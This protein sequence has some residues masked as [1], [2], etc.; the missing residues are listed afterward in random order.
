MP[1]A[2]DH[3]IVW[4]VLSMLLGPTCGAISHE[5]PAWWAE[6]LGAQVDL[7]TIPTS[8]G[9]DPSNS[10]EAL[11]LVAALRA[12]GSFVRVPTRLGSGGELMDPTPTLPFAAD[13]ADVE[14]L[15]TS[16]C[17]D[18]GSEVDVNFR[19]NTSTYARLH[20]HATRW[21][22]AAHER[23]L[24]HSF[25]P[26]FFDHQFDDTGTSS[27]ITFAWLL[28][29]MGAGPSHPSPRLLGDVGAAPLMILEVGSFEGSSATWL[30]ENLLVHPASRLL[31]VDSWSPMPYRNGG[32]TADARQR[33][34]NGHVPH[35]LIETLVTELRNLD[36]GDTENKHGQQAMP[37][38][39]VR[40]RSNLGKTPGGTQVVAGRCRDSASAL[41][42]LLSRQ[43]RDGPIRFFDFIYI[44]GEH[45]F[46]LPLVLRGN[47]SC[48]SKPRRPRR[49]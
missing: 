11:A 35:P 7:F 21:Y 14:A 28:L 48:P 29:D 23:R 38:A 4:A 37:R 33:V 30:A 40:F 24:E 44:D 32:D 34:T 3:L 47:C 26:P 9:R 46:S 12:P 1:N 6:G 16:V 20:L 2:R 45:S 5:V 17:G 10:F 42:G 39:L 41:A 49:A 27:V 15:A 13:A 19:V 22:V 31:C 43:P 8:P 18:G 36:A 25:D